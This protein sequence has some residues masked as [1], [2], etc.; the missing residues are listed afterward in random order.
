LIIDF[1]ASPQPKNTP[2]ATL[3]FDISMAS[4]PDQFCNRH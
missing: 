2:S 3:T 4:D 1:C